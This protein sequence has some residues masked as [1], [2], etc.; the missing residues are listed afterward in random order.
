MNGS[1]RRVLGALS[2]LP[3]A[4]A[5]ERKARCRRCG[6]VLDAASAFRVELAREGAREAFDTPKCAFTVVRRKGTPAGK[7]TFLGYY[8]KK[9]LGEEAL[10]FAVGSD[11]LG[12]MGPDFIPVEREHEAKFRKEHHA[13]RMIEAS[14]ITLQLAEGL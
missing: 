9:P 1:R 2:A 3:F 14:E 10:L 8:T 4:P 12:P 5:C 13:E 6:M 11:V 7:L